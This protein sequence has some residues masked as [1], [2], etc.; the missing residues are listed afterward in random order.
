LRGEEFLAKRDY[1]R[2]LADFDVV[3]RLG[4]NN[5][6]GYDLRGLV[7]ERMDE[8]DKAL[9]DYRRALSLESRAG[10]AKEGLQRL[11]QPPELKLAE[12]LYDR[13]LAHMRTGEYDSAIAD[14][15]QAVRLDP[16]LTKSVFRSRAQAFSLNGEYARAIPDWT[17][18]IQLE[19]RDQGAWFDRGVAYFKSGDYDQAIADFSE[20]LR[21]NSRHQGAYVSRG[22]AYAQKGE[23]ERAI[24]DFDEVIRSSA[25]PLSPYY[26]RGFAHEKMNQREKAIADYRKVLTFD[27]EVVNG[28]LRMIEVDEVELSKQGLRR[29]GEMP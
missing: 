5:F 25:G 17:M 3:V 29:L 22:E 12:R 6:R 21:I 23:Y 14:C 2:A 28:G 20:V 8:R 27:P 24:A 13:C 4:P 7:Y 18:V 1:P 15:D 9:A 26:Q 11:T 10:I 16:K 19:P